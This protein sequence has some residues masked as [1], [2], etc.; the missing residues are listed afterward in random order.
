MTNPWP[1]G[2]TV[3]A[4]AVGMKT[5]PPMGDASSATSVAIA[6]RFERTPRHVNDLVTLMISP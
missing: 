1:T 5:G 4:V 2:A 3:C 6:Q